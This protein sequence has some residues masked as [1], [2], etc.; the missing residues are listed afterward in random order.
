MRWNQPMLLQCTICRR[1][2]YDISQIGNECRRR[3]WWTLWLY[4]CP[5]WLRLVD[6][7][8]SHSNCRYQVKEKTA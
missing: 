1:L 4:P 6:P 2:E 7:P 5:G 3:H 8:S